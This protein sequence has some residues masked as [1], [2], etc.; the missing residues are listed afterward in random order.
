MFKKIMYSALLSST[1]IANSVREWLYLE[2]PGVFI[3]THS[4]YLWT[5]TFGKKINTPILLI[6]GAG[7]HRKFWPDSFC[8]KLA[9]YGF[10]VI[11]FD[12][13]DSGFS[14]RH[15]IGSAEKPSYT[16]FDIIT[17]IQE[18]LNFYNISKAHVIG[19]SMGG[20]IVAGLMAYKSEIVLSATIIGSGDIFTQ[21]EHKEFQLS[22]RSKNLIQKLQSI[23]PIGIH[24]FDKKNLKKKIE[25][26]HGDYAINEDLFNEYTKE[27]YQLFGGKPHL[28]NHIIML[29][30]TRPK[31][32]CKDLKKS[33]VRTLVIHGTKDYL[34]P[35]DWGKT[36]A[37]QIPNAQ[38]FPLKDAGHMYCDPDLWN[39]ILNKIITFLKK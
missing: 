28:K 15:P 21:D 30:N 35:Y 11:R 34:V 2:K 12:L 22:L 32:L 13:R 36:V 9:Q 37:E 1:F 17:D 29:F 19:H 10:F 6:H 26:I 25:L 14:Q 16:F 38:F 24:F 31:N 20:C 23:K 3:T 33:L 8:K 7:S 27:F 39:I 4:S 5:E 18:V